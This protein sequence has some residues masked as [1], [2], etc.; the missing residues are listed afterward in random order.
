MRSTCPL[1]VGSTLLFLSTEI[2]W[3]DYVIICAVL[4]LNK[5]FTAFT[6]TIASKLP[7][8]LFSVVY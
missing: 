2:K 5:P 4:D 1:S 3:P 6:A 8:S 7:Y